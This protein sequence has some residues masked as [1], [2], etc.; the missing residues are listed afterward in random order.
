MI[1]RV[2]IIGVGELAGY[3]VEGLLGARPDLQV[4]LSPRSEAVSASL[5]ERFGATVAAN[6]Q[7]VADAADLVFVTTRSPDILAACE[8][9]TFRADQLVVSTAAGV[10]L[11]SL[12]P[13]VAPATVV[14]AMPITCSAINRSPTLLYPD[15]SEVRVLLDLLGSV[16][17]V[18]NE[19]QFTA[20]SAITAFYG[21][22]Y[23]LLDET[24]VWTVREGVPLSTARALVLETARGATEMGMANPDR[25]LSALLDSLATPGGVTREGLKILAEKG[26]LAAWVAA[27]DAVHRRLRGDA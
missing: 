18:D 16:H 24:V 12:K 26:S 17:V 22:V 1:D 25:G 23:A 2:G 19:E 15:Q 8:S 4:A 21:W 7:A 11:A 3:V 13:A 20:A 6:N 10:R 27:L 14:R 5:A 9:V